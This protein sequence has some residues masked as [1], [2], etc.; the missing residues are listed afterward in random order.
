VSLKERDRVKVLA[1][2]VAASDEA[3]ERA[4]STPGPP[5]MT[6]GEVRAGSRLT[7]ACGCEKCVY[8][9]SWRAA[10]SEWWSWMPGHGGRLVAVED[11]G[12][13]RRFGRWR[14]SS[15]RRSA[16]ASNDASGL[17]E[18]SPSGSDRGPFRE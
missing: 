7:P 15:R 17:R 8:S 3:R 6:P 16:V 9:R 13:G 2:E 18:K 10:G 14:V 4:W 12:A 5:A 11:V 1:D